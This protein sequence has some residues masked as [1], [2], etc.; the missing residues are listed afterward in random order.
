[1]IDTHTHLHDKDFDVDR[2]DIIERYKE[3]GIKI[4]NIGTSLED[5][6]QACDLGMSNTGMMRCTVGI[7]PHEAVES[8]ELSINDIQNRLSELVEQYSQVVVGIGE[9]GLDYFR[10]DD[11]KENITK[12]KEVFRTQIE[13]ARKK[14]L[15]LVVHIR[16]A[17]EDTFEICQK[18]ASDLRMIIHCYTGDKY[19]LG[20]FVEISDKVYVGFTGLVTF[21]KKVDDIVDALSG[22]PLEKILVETDAP[23][24]SP[25]PVRGQRNNSSNL[26]HIVAKIAEIKN[27]SVEEMIEILDKNAKRAY[28]AKLF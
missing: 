4:V 7:H 21:K 25:E 28:G 14:D 15:T 8:P 5:S 2:Q 27:L 24:L 26:K 16:D 10:I 9:C 6:K 1:V 12:Q 19:W 20:K 11:N 18:E 3:E 17:W 23:Y 13:L 22:C